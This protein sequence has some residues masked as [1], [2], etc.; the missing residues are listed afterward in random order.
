MKKLLVVFAAMLLFAVLAC[1]SGGDS[2][3][4]TPPPISTAT[5]TGT[6]SGTTIVAYNATTGVQVAST[7]AT[8]S[9]R[10]FTLNL[11]LGVSY[12]FYFIENKGEN[13]RVYPLYQGTTNVFTISSSSAVTID[14]GYVNTTSGKAVPTNNPLSVS[15]VTSGGENTTTPADLTS[16][17][18]SIADLVGTWNIQGITSGDSPQWLG[19]AHGVSSIDSS[20]N[21]TWLS[22]TRSN[23]DSTL[24]AAATLSISS[25]GIVS[26]TYSPSF[27]GVMS[28]DKDTIIATMNDGG[29]G[30]GL[31]TYQKSVGVFTSADLVGTWNIHMI[32]SGDSPQWLGWV[33]SVSSIDSSGNATTSSITRSDGNS[34]LPGTQTISISS[35]GIVSCAGAPSF[36]GVM[37]QDKNTI[38]VTM[39]DGGGYNLIIYQKS[40]GSY[41]TTDL[42]GTWNFH[43][44]T[45]GDSPD[46]LGWAHGVSSIDSSGNATWLSITRSNGD[47]T[48]PAAGTLSISSGGIVSVTG[49][50]SPVFDGFMSQDKNTIIATTND[51]GGGYN[52][53]VFQK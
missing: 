7:T 37:S 41:T 49:V 34:T 17:S 23:G 6:V 31:I 3:G 48:L 27:H 11:P 8:G 38:I 43:L 32:T 30:Y 28:Q 35:S 36:H 14:L 18:F 44:L 42:Q 12:K 1:S 9:P 5:L 26:S 29:G 33:H 19:W 20:G 46:W 16:S 21:A 24:P 2:A 47:S 50:P 39:N 51:G 40:A 4:P 45:S 22:I 10:N 25:S 13:Q 15:G 53:I 52:L